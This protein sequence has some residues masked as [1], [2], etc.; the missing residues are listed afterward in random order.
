MPPMQ[1]SERYRSIAADVYGPNQQIVSLGSGD[2]DQ[3]GVGVRERERK[4]V[5]LCA[6]RD[7]GDRLHEMF[8]VY[9]NDTYVR[10]NKHPKG[11]SLH[12]IKGEADFVFFDDD[13]NMTD[14][15]PLGA[16][17]SQRKFYCRIPEGVYHTWVIRSDEIA[18][19]ESIPGPFRNDQT[20]FA[21]WA[22]EEGDPEAESF[23]ERLSAGAA[24]FLGSR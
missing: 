10:P 5:R 16:Y 7:L 22:P 21:P 24:A 2:I 1:L 13:G 20:T 19:H 14:V 12:I 8:V 11:E 23:M 3:L 4:R 15:V 17:G 18:V 9:V 6:H